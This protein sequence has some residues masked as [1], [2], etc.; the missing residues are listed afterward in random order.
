[1]TSL[2]SFLIEFWYP[3]GKTD[4]DLAR[5]LQV[6]QGLVSKWIAGKIDP[7]LERKI[8]LAREIGVDS[9]QIFPERSSDV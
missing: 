4:S 5:A 6:D 9:R 2:K 8:Q 3:R 7:P 1:M